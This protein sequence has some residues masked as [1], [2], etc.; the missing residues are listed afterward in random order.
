M[1]PV[2]DFV[3]MEKRPKSLM[4]V[5]MDKLSLFFCVVLYKMAPKAKRSNWVKSQ[6]GQV[7]ENAAS[8][9]GDKYIKTMFSIRESWHL[10]HILP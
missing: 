4:L 6:K 7:F 2:L 8:Y 10:V 1:E 9:Y 5:K 3:P